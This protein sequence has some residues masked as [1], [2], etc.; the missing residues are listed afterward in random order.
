MGCLYNGDTQP[1]EAMHSALKD[2]WRFS[3]NHRDDSD[4]Q[5]LRVHCNN[6]ALRIFS[7]A[8]ARKMGKSPVKVQ[9][10]RLASFVR[11]QKTTLSQFIINN[12]GNPDLL[13]LEEKALRYIRSKVGSHVDAEDIYVSHCRKE[14]ELSNC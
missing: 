12:P 11:Q 9:P 8:V 5:M 7:N 14:S 13:C 4:Q 3:C 6:E 2:I 10:A 1:S